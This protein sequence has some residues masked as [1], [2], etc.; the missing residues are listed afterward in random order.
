MPETA[1]YFAD[2]ARNDTGAAYWC[3]TADGVRI[4]IGVFA[5][6]GA[7]GTVLLFPGRTEFVEKYGLTAADLAARGYASLAIDWR[8]QGLADR[9]H[10]NQLI[11]HVGR[12]PDY[13]H[14]ARAALALARELGLPEPFHMIGHSM[15][16][17]IGL[18]ALYEAYPVE[19][20]VF[21]APKWGIYM[22]PALRPVA[23]GLSALSRP[24][25]FSGV[26]APG[27]RGDP[28][29]LRVGLDENR[30][31][32]DAQMFALMQEQVT[33][34]PELS[35]GGPSLHWLHESLTEM[36]DL[37]ARPAPATPCLTF[38][39]SEEAI[40][41]AA[42]IRARIDTWPNGELIVI[43]GARHEVLLEG[44][45]VRKTILDRCAAFFDGHVTA[46]A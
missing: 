2:I 14:D 3:T 8:G 41:D 39:G 42:A 27:Q 22:G 13:Q 16:G 9:V 35:I 26:M 23:W 25:G 29:V 19:T 36:R 31:T 30:L 32:S 7:R 15:G 44:P 21:S 18:R 46:E 33:K 20:A 38:L 37:M 11:G 28:Y 12:F 40:V 24:L 10:R 43:D 1:P 6:T 17:C 5:S 4:R 34:H 45:T